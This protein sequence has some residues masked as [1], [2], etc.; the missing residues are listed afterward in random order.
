[1]TPRIIHESILKD[2]AEEEED[3]DEDPFTGLGEEEA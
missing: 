2:L 1:M 3:N